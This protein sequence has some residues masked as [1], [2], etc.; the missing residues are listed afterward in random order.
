[1]KHD[2]VRPRLGTAATVALTTVALLAFAANSL[3]CRAALR[4]GLVDAASFTSVRLASGALAL[5]LVARL[6]GR[7]G[8]SSTG[9]WLSALALFAY[10]AFFSFAYLRLDAGVGAL[11]LF[12]SVQ[13][14]MIGWGLAAGERPRSAEWVGLAVSLLG[15]VLLTRPGLT[16]PDPAGTLLMALAGVAW[17]AYSLRGRASPDAVADNASNFAR[18]V[19]M[20]LAASLLAI[21]QAHLSTGGVLLAGASGALTSGV[22]YAVWFLA[23]RGLTPARAAM[24]QLAVPVLAAVGGV[25][26][27][28][29]R[30]TLRLLAAGILVLGG[31]ALAVTARRPAAVV[32]APAPEA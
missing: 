2:S 26:F 15:L 14:T 25:L 6:T 28:G 29:E 7:G 19:P 30:V 18:T 13:A 17:G 8:G 4:P 23:L 22:G 20:A 16:S 24:V 27:L 11:V 1:M 3:L 32:A 10:A 9:S 21:G 12:G 5:V 31:I